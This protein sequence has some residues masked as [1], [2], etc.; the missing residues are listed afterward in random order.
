MGD[1]QRFSLCVEGWRCSG[2]YE[3][4]KDADAMEAQLKQEKEQ[5]AAQD[6]GSR[7]MGTATARRKE[8]QTATLV[9]EMLVND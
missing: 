9:D 4:W 1:T 7:G 5:E 2:T 3:A 8:L 6:L